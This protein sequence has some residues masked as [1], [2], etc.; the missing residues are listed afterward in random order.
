VPKT[1]YRIRMVELPLSVHGT[2]VPNT[3]GSFDVFINSRLSQRDREETIEH[4]LSHIDRDHFHSRRSIASIE[5]E[6]EG[7]SDPVLSPPEGKLPCFLSE[8]ALS[9]WICAMMADL[10]E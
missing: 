4:E 7:G 2:T 6:A 9:R 3:D 10:K 8:E 1:D 5:R